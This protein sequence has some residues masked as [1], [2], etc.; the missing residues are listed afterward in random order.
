MTL[1]V[2]TSLGCPP[3]THQPPHQPSPE[4][5]I[6]A[7]WRC[8]REEPRSDTLQPVGACRV[9][10]RKSSLSSPRISRCTPP[11]IP[12]THIHTHTSR[13]LPLATQVSHPP[14]DHL[15]FTTSAVINVLE[16]FNLL[17]DAGKNQDRRLPS[18]LLPAP[19]ISPPHHLTSHDKPHLSRSPIS[20]LSLC[21]AAGGPQ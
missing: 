4:L 18:V 7:W 17:P 2:D 1:A 13:F 20:T 9:I 6:T 15:S 8:W 21:L 11:P 5:D 10:R 16:G 19:Y 14:H 12:T 3:L